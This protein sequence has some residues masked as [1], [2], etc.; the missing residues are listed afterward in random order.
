MRMS[1]LET[2]VELDEVGQ[3][4]SQTSLHVAASNDRFFPSM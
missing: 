2:G 1:F 4:F 3:A